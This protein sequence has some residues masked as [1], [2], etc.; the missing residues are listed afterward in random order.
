MSNYLKPIN[1]IKAFGLVEILV[2]LVIYG[3]AI[4][5]VTA[6]TISSYRTVKDNEIG[7][8]ANSLMVRGIEYFK[9]P[10]AIAN[11][12]INNGETRVFNLNTASPNDVGN[13][14]AQFIPVIVTSL[15]WAGNPTRINI[16]DC[17]ASSIFK[18]TFASGVNPYTMC[19]QIIVQKTSTKD[20]LIQSVVV[21][22]LSRRF[23]QNELIGFRPRLEL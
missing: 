17:T 3:I 23:E 5:G 4:I 13:P 21:F 8:L 11:L 18:I 6:L 7:D 16:S 20:Y 19:N 9:S 14:A 15:P 22:Q 12:P 1:K 2:S 10:N